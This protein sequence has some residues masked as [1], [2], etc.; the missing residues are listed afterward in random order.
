MLLVPG[1]NG[2]GTGKIIHVPCLQVLHYAGLHR[3]RVYQ[4]REYPVFHRDP[5]SKYPL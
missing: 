4:D 1:I 5:V 2:K 3:D